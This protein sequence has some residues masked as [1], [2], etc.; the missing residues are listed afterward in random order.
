[1]TDPTP[2]PLVTLAQQWREQA[3]ATRSLAVNS[4]DQGRVSQSDKC[5]DE[6]DAALAALVP[7]QEQETGGPIPLNAAQEQA[8]KEWAADDRLWTTQDTVEVNLRTFARVILR[9]SDRPQPIGLAGNHRA[10]PIAEAQPAALRAQIDPLVQ[11]IKDIEIGVGEYGRQTMEVNPEMVRGLRG[12]EAARRQLCQWADTLAA[13]GIA[14][15]E[16]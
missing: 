16:A 11:A 12:I 1:M 7:T 15:K 4:F 2:H 3:E 14:E 5:A 8:V 13:P 9:H 6:L 10:Q